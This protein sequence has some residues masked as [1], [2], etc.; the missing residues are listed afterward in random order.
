MTDDDRQ[1]ATELDTIIANDFAS[2]RDFLREVERETGWK[3][4]EPTLSKIRHGKLKAPDPL[5]RWFVIKFPLG[6]R[7]ISVEE[8]R[9]GS[10]LLRLLRR[11]LEEKE[12][13]V[14][15]HSATE[16]IAAYSAGC[17]R[18]EGPEFLPIVHAFRA[19]GYLGI[20]SVA[21]TIRDYRKATELARQFAP[22]LCPRYEIGAI[23][24]ESE[25]I[26]KSFNNRELGKTFWQQR[27]RSMVS[28]L[29]KIKTGCPTDEKMRLQSLLRNTARLDD[30]DSFD[31][32][33]AGAR[34]HPGFGSTPEK[35]DACLRKWMSEKND[36]DGDFRKARSY[37]SFADLFN[38]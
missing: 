20:D 35:R 30:R 21:E 5:R 17:L 19:V 3:C 2:A 25:S 16:F 26:N 31:H 6:T 8:D 23:V 12:F 36:D 7:T 24:W 4:T 14:L 37:Q 15:I 34:K 28:Q 11:A 22:R 29:E 33:L 1:L 32:W 13:T 9:D 27:L 38:R 18:A 10:K